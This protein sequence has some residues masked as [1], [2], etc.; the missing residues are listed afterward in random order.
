[1]LCCSAANQTVDTT[2]FEMSY[3]FQSFVLENGN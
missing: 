2:Q 3:V 1:M